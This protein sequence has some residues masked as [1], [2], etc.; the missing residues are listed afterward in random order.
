L[1]VLKAIVQRLREIN[2][3]R[4]EMELFKEFILTYPVK[5]DPNEMQEEGGAPKNIADVVDY[6]K[7]ESIYD[8]LL[9]LLNV[10]KTKEKIESIL[11][12]VQFLFER[13]RDD[14]S[15]TVK[16]IYD[17]LGPSDIFLL[18]AKHLTS[19]AL[20]FFIEMYQN[21]TNMSKF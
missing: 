14:I 6:L 12:F 15:Q 17:I 19:R 21:P 2:T 11:E 18:W 4:S 16:A 13:D 8:V 1:E 5:V 7:K 9:R 3:V 20:S 10:V